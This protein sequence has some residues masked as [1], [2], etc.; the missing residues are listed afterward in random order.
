M[1]GL[2]F[3]GLKRRLYDDIDD[4]GGEAFDLNDECP[5]LF[6]ERGDEFVEYLV[7]LRLRQCA[8]FGELLGEKFDHLRVAVLGRGHGP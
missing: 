4:R 7:A 1:A 6:V 3:A 2:E 5:E 8:A